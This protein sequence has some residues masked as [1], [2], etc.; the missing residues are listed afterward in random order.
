VPDLN[1]QVKKGSIMRPIGFESPAKRFWRSLAV[2]LLA[3]IVAVV[4]AAL[5][6]F[7]HNSPAAHPALSVAV[8]AFGLGFFAGFGLALT[9]PDFAPPQPKDDGDAEAGVQAR[10]VPPVPTLGL[11]IMPEA[12]AKNV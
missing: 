7:A 3:A 1:R 6:L 12:D 11:R 9:W 2:G 4:M 5:V 8:S 10:L